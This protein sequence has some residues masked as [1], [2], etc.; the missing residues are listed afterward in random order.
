[1]QVVVV[2]AG[3]MGCATALELAARGVRDILVLERAVPGAEASSA[4]AGM[5]AAQIESQDDDELGRFVAARDAY[6]AWALALREQ[7]G[8]DVGHR[9]SGALEII[10]DEGALAKARVR[11][12][13]HRARGLRAELLDRT[14]AI[15]V[16]RTL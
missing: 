3:I 4:A 12:D 6:E 2:G 7:T 11:V 16:E 8:I 14:Q 10:R 5:L 13:R 15:A 1:M 9:R